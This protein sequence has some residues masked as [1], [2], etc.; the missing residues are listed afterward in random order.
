[1]QVTRWQIDFRRWEICPKRVQKACT[2][3]DFGTLFW[4]SYGWIIVNYN[5]WNEIVSKARGMAIRE[6]SYWYNSLHVERKL[7]LTISIY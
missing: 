4:H 6:H 2:F 3:R 7:K 1:M 5:P